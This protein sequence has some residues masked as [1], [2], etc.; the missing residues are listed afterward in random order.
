MPRPGVTFNVRYLPNHPD[1]FLIV[2]DDESAYVRELRCADVGRR[3]E[4]AR[5]RADFEPQNAAVRAE[6]DKLASEWSACTRSA[7]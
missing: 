7:P 1:A 4:E 3:A 6:S 5:A 2:T